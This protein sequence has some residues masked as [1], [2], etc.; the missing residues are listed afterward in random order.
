MEVDVK[1]LIKETFNDG[2]VIGFICGII[3][4]AMVSYFM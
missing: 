2:W 4:A 1:E 3:M